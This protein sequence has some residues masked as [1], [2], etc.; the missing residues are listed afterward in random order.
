MSEPAATPTKCTRCGKAIE[1]TGIYK[2]I[3]DQA[4]DPVRRK[5][6]VRE[7][8][9]PFCSMEHATHEQMSREG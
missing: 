7:Q 8:Y 5:K 9:L 2:T 6:Y 4:Y 3:I 1:I